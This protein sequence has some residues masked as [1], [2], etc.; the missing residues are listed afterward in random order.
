MLRI[1]P[2]IVL[3]TSL[4]AGDASPEEA[5]RIGWPGYAG[6]TGNLLPL[7]TT[8]PLVE[9]PA[10][11]R[12]AWISEDADI[13][14]AKTGSQSFSTSAVVEQRIGPEPKAHPG[15]WA[16]V[17]V[18]DGRVFASTFKPSGEVFTAPYASSKG[19]DGQRGPEVPTRFRVEAEDLL[20]CFDAATGTVLWKAREPG[21]VILSGGK[22]GGFQIA[23]AVE[24]GRVFAVGSTGRL[25]AYEASSGKKLWQGEIEGTHDYAEK[26]RQEAL[27]A[28]KAGKMVVPD[29]PEWFTSVVAA[30]GI[31]VTADFDGR[32]D[33]GLRT[34]EAAT[35]KPLWRAADCLSRYATPSLVRIDGASYL[36]CGTASG[37]LSL[38]RLADGKEMWRLDGLG[39]NWPSLAPGARTV[40]VNVKKTADKKSKGL[41]GAVR[42]SASSAE[43][44]WKLPDDIANQH[45]IWLDD[46]PR[47]FAFVRDGK[48]LVHTEGAPR[49]GTPGRILLLDEET[50]AVLAETPNQAEGPYALR[51][52]V[53]WLGDRALVREDTSHGASHGGR[54]PLV[55]WDIVPGRIEPRRDEGRLGGIDLVDFDSAYEVMMHLPMVD[56]RLFDRIEDG[57]L[58]CYDLRRTATART[59]VLSLPGAQ[60]GMPPQEVRL[61]LDGSSVT[62][63]KAWIPDMQ[64]AGIPYGRQRRDAMWQRADTTGLS[65]AGDRLHGTLRIDAVTHAWPV[66]LDLRL[67]ADAATGTW[68]REVAALAKPGQTAGKVAGRVS[69]ERAY[70]TP[71]LKDKP[72]TRIGENP[73]GT[74]T[75]VLQL[76]GAIAIR[77]DGNKGITVCLDHD[78]KAWTRAAAAAFSFS[79]AW[80]D[81]DPAGLAIDGDRLH[82]TMTVVVN[83]DQWIDVN[84]GG[85]AAGTITV[86]ATRQADGSL[87]GTFTA[88]W[89]APWQANGQATGTIRRSQ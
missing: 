72:W 86:D 36:M 59:V 13:G 35:G 29:G 85:S 1:V 22:R 39:Q 4:A 38:W 71:W 66:Q 7:R 43:V 21:G 61:W 58:A 42:F 18:A 2:V 37:V 15:N 74:Q 88:A 30:D 28:A 84:Q 78:G 10:Q 83:G 24:G 69:P 47:Q 52:L 17:V 19:K 14:T 46:G 33:H 41:W 12:L 67:T 79:Q 44:A 76:E 81:V 45:S 68:R 65:L 73:A 89:G 77:E 75:W 34:Y 56:G 25:F 55:L 16:N 8:T 53:L 87:Q 60:P 50:G 49:Q 26:G 31:V 70:P 20:I 6:P 3:A 40:M 27:A 23:P 82:G 51:E 64:Q 57:R 63:G 11:A 54:H 5:W 48:V 32:G 9:D 80:H 62:G